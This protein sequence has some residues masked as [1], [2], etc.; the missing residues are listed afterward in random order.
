MSLSFSWKKIVHVNKHRSGEKFDC[1]METR[2]HANTVRWLERLQSGPT[3]AEEFGM[4]YFSQI[5]DQIIEWKALR[6]LICSL[7]NHKRR[8]IHV[9][10]F[11]SHGHTNKAE[12]KARYAN[13]DLFA[14]QRKMTLLGQIWC[15][16]RVYELERTNKSMI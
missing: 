14:V 6:F 4:L 3:N 16:H 13:V 7:L 5:T 1:I 11:I 15:V 8:I 10:T 2:V 9:L 12:N